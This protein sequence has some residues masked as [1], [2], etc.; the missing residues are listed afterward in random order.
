MA[1]AAPPSDWQKSLRRSD[2]PNII[3][4]AKAKPAAAVR[5]KRLQSVNEEVFDENVGKP[6]V[7]ARG[8]GQRRRLSTRESISEVDQVSEKI[9]RPNRQSSPN[10]K[11]KALSFLRRL[12]ACKLTVEQEQQRPI[13]SPI[14]LPPGVTSKL[15]DNVSFA[16]N[17]CFPI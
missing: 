11:Q 1:Y 8:N 7:P 15:F 13:P 17:P 16:P 6:Y 9:S 4:A 5:S 14:P 3:K 10:K 2:G 12:P